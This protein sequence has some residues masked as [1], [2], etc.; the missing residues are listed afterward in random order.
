MKSVCVK[1]E[2]CTQP[3]P[4]KQPEKFSSRY[5]MSSTLGFNIPAMIRSNIYTKEKKR[6]Y[7]R[8]GK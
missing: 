1:G 8:K 2:S 7:K 6:I 3:P 4:A 5:S